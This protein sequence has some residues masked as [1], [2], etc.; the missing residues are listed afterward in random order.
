M[1]GLV[2][3]EE[4]VCDGCW[5]VRDGGEAVGVGEALRMSMCLYF[6]LGFWV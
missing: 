3:A 6:G 1:V 4:R 2:G 5:S